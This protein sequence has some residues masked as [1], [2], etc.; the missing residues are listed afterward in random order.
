MLR[1]ALAAALLGAILGAGFAGCGSSKERE[2]YNRT[3]SD[4]ARMVGLTVADGGAAFGY[5]ALPGP[6]PPGLIALSSNDVCPRDAGSA[7]YSETVCQLGWE[8]FPNDPGLCSNQTGGC[9]YGCEVRATQADLAANGS[10]AVVCSARFFSGQ[11]CGPFT[12]L[13]L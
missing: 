11:P 10:A 9:V 5:Q 3:R 13:C 8:F 2:L 7:T 6:C 4:C 1:P 12:G